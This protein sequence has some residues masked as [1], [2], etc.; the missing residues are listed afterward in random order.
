MKT[1]ALG[2]GGGMVVGIAVWALGAPA[3]SAQELC[4]GRVCP[5]SFTCESTTHVC[6]P[7]DASRQNARRTPIARRAGAVV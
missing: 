7:D 6:G 2:W 5:E 1:R 3:A 4:D